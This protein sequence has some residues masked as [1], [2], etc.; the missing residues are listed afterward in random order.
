[1]STSICL[2]LLFRID[3]YLATNSP[4]AA[5]VERFAED[6]GELLIRHRWADLKHQLISLREGK[7]ARIPANNWEL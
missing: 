3:L 1:M 5:C 6:C 7:A 2:D 4:V